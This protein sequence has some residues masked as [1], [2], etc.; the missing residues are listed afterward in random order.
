[1]GRSLRAGIS[2]LLPG[3]VALTHACMPEPAASP[4]PASA[5]ADA[6]PAGDAASTLPADCVVVL[7]VAAEVTT[8]SDRELRVVAENRQDEPVAFVLPERCPA[9]L[10]DFEGLGPNY[11]YYSTCN[12]GACLRSNGS[13]TITLAPHEQR[14]LATTVIHVAGEEPCT[15][16]LP[17]GRLPVR[18]VL[19]RAPFPLCSTTAFIDVPDP[20]PHREASPAPPPSRVPPPGPEPALRPPVPRPAGADCESAADCEIFCPSAPGCCGNPC[21]CQSASP[22]AKHA[23][24]E[25][26]FPKSCRR[27]PCPAMGCAFQPA[28]GATCRDHRCVAVR[29]LSEF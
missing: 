12:A 9:G 24:I 16:P 8:P 21:G 26:A 7:H 6:G 11:D 20:P 10:V 13:T 3:M 19:P 4:G 27:T 18:A 17:R 15:R 29:S 28:M 25:R 14:E 1:M 23:E 5:P 22:R 2:L